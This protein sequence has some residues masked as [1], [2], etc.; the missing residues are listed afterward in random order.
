[1][2]VVMYLEIG[3]LAGKIESVALTPVIAYLFSENDKP[4]IYPCG[5][6]I[7]SV[8]KFLSEIEY[9][10]SR[11]GDRYDSVYPADPIQAYPNTLLG[12]AK[13]NLSRRSQI[14]LLLGHPFDSQ[15]S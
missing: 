11:A 15:R 12:P 5:Y 13:M 8:V 14:K 6:V 7:N 2:K 4:L 1:M 9:D 3:G 10:E